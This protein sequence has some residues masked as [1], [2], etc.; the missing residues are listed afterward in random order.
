MKQIFE[1]MRESPIVRRT[2]MYGIVGYACAITLSP[3][4]P[5][6]VTATV[7]LATTLFGYIRSRKAELPNPNTPLA[8]TSL[9]NTN[10]IA[11]STPIESA[12]PQSTM[13]EWAQDVTKYMRVMEEMVVEE[14]KSNSI[15]NEITEK[16]VLLLAKIGRV[17]PYLEEFN[18]D[19]EKHAIRRLVMRDLN[20]IILPFLKLPTNLKVQNRRK[21][22]DG[23]KE[24]SGKLETISQNIQQ[25]DLMELEKGL[26]LISS[27]YNSKDIY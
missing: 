22:L 17:M 20:S 13:S 18:L 12:P 8:A 10:A 11:P 26:A 2:F 1:Y 5:E 4:L 14:G 27:R 25:K 21:V 9:Q 15:D 24:V 3:I 7:P 23:I 19:N 16:V 6:V